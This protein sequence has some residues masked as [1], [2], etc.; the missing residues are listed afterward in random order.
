[1]KFFLVRILVD[2]V[3]RVPAYDPVTLEVT[4]EK[5]LAMALVRGSWNVDNRHVDVEPGLVISI[6]DATTFDFF[7]SRGRARA[8]CAGPGD[9]LAIESEAD[10]NYLIGS[11]RAVAP[12]R[13]ECD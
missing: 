4:G 11:S 5:R 7:V 6:A 12:S 10:F 13:N 8:V 2:G 9:V 1:M 3:D